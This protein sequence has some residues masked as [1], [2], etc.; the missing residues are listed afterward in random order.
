[1]IADDYAVLRDALRRRLRAAVALELLEG[2][3]NVADI[4]RLVEALKPDVVVLDMYLPGL[5]GLAAIQELKQRSCATRVLVLAIDR[6]EDYLRAA[7]QAGADG[8]VLHSASLAE[9]LAGIDSVLCGKRFIS[10][11]VSEQIVHRYLEQEDPRAQGHPDLRALTAREREVLRMIARGRRNREIAISLSLSVKTVEKHRANLM[12]KL[13][14]HNTA[15][16]TSFAVERGI[17]RE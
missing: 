11:A 6:T 1:M 12:N 3:D 4:A 10:G 13:G 15:A 5:A 17:A 14:L 16:L 9:M 7:F 8:Y 2:L